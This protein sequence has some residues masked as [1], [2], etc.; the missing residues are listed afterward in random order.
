MMRK[1]SFLVG[2]MALLVVGDSPAWAESAAPVIIGVP[3]YTGDLSCEAAG[4]IGMRITNIGSQTI[5][6][7]AKVEWTLIASPEAGIAVLDDELAP[8]AGHILDNGRAD[9]AVGTFPC[10]AKVVLR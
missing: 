10:K 3:P 6:A 9:G 5:I 7:G 8:G 4:P 1:A 2:A